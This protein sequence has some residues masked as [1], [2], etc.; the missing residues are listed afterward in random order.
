VYS[1]DANGGGHVAA[2][3]I[4][5]AALASINIHKAFQDIPTNARRDRVL[6]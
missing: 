5:A 1:E 4:I 2:P 6:N 3:G